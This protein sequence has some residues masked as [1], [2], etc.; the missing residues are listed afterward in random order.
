[1]AEQLLRALR[2]LVRR[3]VYSSGVIAALALALTLVVT[4]LTIADR[5]IWRP[6]PLTDSE[7]LF[8]VFEG[9]SLGARR[10]PSYPT[11]RDWSSQATGFDGFA[12]VRG[13]SDQLRGS[14]AIERVVVAIGSPGFA[15]VIG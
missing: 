14:E 10:L 4:M 15:R 9:G 13:E 6:L 7:R 2:T 5:V 1:M 3:P 11:V 8:T 12:F